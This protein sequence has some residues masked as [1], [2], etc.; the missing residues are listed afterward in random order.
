[1]IGILNGKVSLIEDHAIVDVGGVGYIVYCSLRHLSGLTEGSQVT[2]FIETYVREDRID[3]YGFASL[4]E[5][6]LFNKLL[7]I[8]GVG[9]RMALAVL[10]ALTY[11]QAL[12]AIS[13]QDKI[14]F[15]SVSGIGSKLAGR[16]VTELKDVV[17]RAPLSLNLPIIS[18]KLA[19][20][21]EDLSIDAISALTNLGI[22]R[23]DAMNIV[24]EVLIAKPD[25]SLDELIK[26][27][28]KARKS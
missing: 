16:I 9:P 14:I 26:S 3:L 8:S 13:A 1:M 27:A 11:E 28:L 12:K 21:T 22:N 2:I 23:Y 17:S 20:K 24:S 6:W 19:N 18:D 10:S 7:S 4:S 25:I 15:Q 5:K